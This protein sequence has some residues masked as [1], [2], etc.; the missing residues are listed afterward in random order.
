M[1]LL[2]CSKEEVEAAY[3]SNVCWLEVHG[4]FDTSKLC[5]NTAYEV[6]FEVMLKDPAYGWEVPINLRLVGPDGKVQ[7]RTGKLMDIP[8]GRWVMLHVG[9][10]PISS[11]NSGGQVEY[12]L[13]EYHGGNWKRGLLVK[14]AIIRLK[15]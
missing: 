3:L 9:E 8:R 10:I 12:S 2:T 6:M 13:Y 4:K 1:T 7:E 11:E 5:E 15:I 14:G